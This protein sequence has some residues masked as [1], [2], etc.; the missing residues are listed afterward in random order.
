MLR[1]L[2]FVAGALAAGLT[3][4]WLRRVGRDDCMP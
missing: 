4:W 3:F 1:I 2:P